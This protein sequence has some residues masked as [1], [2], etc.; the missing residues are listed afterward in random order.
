MGNGSF[1]AAMTSATACGS[2]LVLC[3][4]LLLSGSQT[5]AH[6]TDRPDL[7]DWFMSLRSKN[8]LCCSFA[9]AEKL[10]DV[11]WD[12]RDDGHY[13]VFLDDHWILVPDSAVLTVPNKHGQAIVWPIRYDGKV[14]EIRCFI[15]GAGA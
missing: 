5:Q 15:P 1:S 4:V 8:G 2:A 11:Q 10:T 14:T 13:Q 9:D 6:M 7:D 3:A 12:I